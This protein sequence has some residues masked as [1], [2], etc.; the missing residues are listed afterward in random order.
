MNFPFSGY[1][2]NK[3]NNKLVFG[4][5]RSK[6]NQA[7]KEIQI[8]ITTR[9]AIPNAMDSSGVQRSDV[10]HWSSTIFSQQAYV[11]VLID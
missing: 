8:Q 11:L 4:I 3:V 10:Y 9:T 6:Q 7:T 1:S 2:R 5:T